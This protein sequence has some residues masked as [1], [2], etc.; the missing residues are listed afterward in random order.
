[1]LTGKLTILVDN[2]PIHFCNAYCKV[3]KVTIQACTAGPGGETANVAA[4]RVTAQKRI[5]KAIAPSLG[6]QDASN[7]VAGL[8]GV[9]GTGIV[10]FPGD[11]IVWGGAQTGTTIDMAD[12]FL[13]GTAGDAVNWTAEI[14]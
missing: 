14:F 7:Q 9:K 3:N 8:D 6:P 10:L 12:L 11:S 13:V 4:V 1:M 5:G 2:T